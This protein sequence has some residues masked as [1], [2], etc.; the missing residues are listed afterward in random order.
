M[1]SP[2]MYKYNTGK[3]GILEDNTRAIILY[4]CILYPCLP[5][6]QVDFEK[7]PLPCGLTTLDVIKMTEWNGDYSDSL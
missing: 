7:V 1:L 5:E 4:H 2:I 6:E 3:D